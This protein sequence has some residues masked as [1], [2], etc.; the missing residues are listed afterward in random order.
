MLLVTL[1]N[2]CASV[3]GRTCNE[4]TISHA[5]IHEGALVYDGPD[6]RTYRRIVIP[7][8]REL[9]MAGVV[10]VLPNPGRA[11]K[12]RLFPFGSA[13]IRGGR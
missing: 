7:A 4:C 9:V 11:N 2:E 1:A 8:L 5:E 6:R 13:G 10:E 3:R 12:Y